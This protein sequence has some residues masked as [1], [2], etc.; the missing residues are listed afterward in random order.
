MNKTININLGGLFFHIDEMAFQ[1]LKRY[2]DTIRHSLSD[3]SKGC[4]EIIADIEL[5]IS[6][7][8]SGKIK[9]PRQVIGEADIDE[10][11]GIMGQ[12]ED[13]VFE[14][15]PLNDHQ[16][17]STQYQN[18]NQKKLFRD[19]DD[20]F[21]GG[22]A[23]GIGHYFGI[24][25]IWIRLIWLLLAFAGFGFLLYI[26]LWILVP[27]AKTTA[28]K[29][30]MEGEAVNISTIERKI[31]DEFQDVSQRAKKG[32]DEASEKVKEGF[33]DAK[34]RVNQ[35][36]IKSGFQ[37]FIDV[38]GKIFTTFFLVIGKFIGILL[39]IV[40]VATLIGLGVGLFAAGSLDLSGFDWFWLGDANFINTTGLPIWA[41]SI[42]V[43]LLVGI[44]FLML[45]FL[46]M[47]ILSSR[48]KTPGRITWYVLLGLWLITIITAIFFSVKQSANYAYNGSFIE[49][50]PI[51][52]AQIDTLSIAM[53]DNQDF[54]NYGY[55]RKRNGFKRV[56]TNDNK[57]KLYA[58]AIRLNIAVADGDSS[59]VKI[60][61]EGQGRNR[62]LAQS[63]AKNIEYHF[64][65]NGK[66]LNLDGFFLT[67]DGLNSIDKVLD[68]TIL[69]PKNKII[70]IDKS[71]Q[72]FLRHIENTDNT[73]DGDLPKHLYKMT[74][75]GLECL[76]CK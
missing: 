70:Y 19:G 13:Y 46:G 34:T 40:S 62:A 47:F 36:Q 58:N 74:L 23:A 6:E 59:Y 8:L 14:D 71:T 50:N 37:E 60:R 65:L 63:N 12:P 16:K 9:D 33:K 41:V 73:F 32:F 51:E 22:V 5:R 27:V 53:V 49:N 76:D 57:A 54:S 72:S 67:N 18:Y 21:L 28:E 26:I 25:P 42:M 15:E 55:L 1:K 4:D 43:F 11:I 75:S 24:E 17:Y 45:F 64:A 48:S 68:I 39:I 44:P 35:N 30:Q 38:I 20:K 7:L 3:D 61:K 69:I 56:Y 29:L 31:R 52:L 66:T 10:V 2:L